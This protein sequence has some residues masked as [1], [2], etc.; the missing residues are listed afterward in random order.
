MLCTAS[1][2]FHDWTGDV[3]GV[4]NPPPPGVIYFSD[5]TSELSRD[6]QKAEVFDYSGRND[7]D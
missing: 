5:A 4:L 3:L 7:D 2:C 6:I 1:E